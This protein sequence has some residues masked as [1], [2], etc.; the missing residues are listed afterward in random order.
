[1][2]RPK[3]D[4]SDNLPWSISLLERRLRALKLKAGA[5]SDTESA[6][7]MR[8]AK[9]ILFAEFHPAKRSA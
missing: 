9:R 6:R 7:R 3:I 4:P 2:P 1:M 5:E 8:E